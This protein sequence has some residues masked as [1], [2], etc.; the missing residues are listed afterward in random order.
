MIVLIDYPVFMKPHL[1]Y[2]DKFC[3]YVAMLCSS[4]AQHINKDSTYVIIDLE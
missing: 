4:F 1:F 2:G 3:N